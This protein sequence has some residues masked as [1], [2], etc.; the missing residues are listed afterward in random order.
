MFYDISQFFCC[1]TECISK[2]EALNEKKIY[3]TTTVEIPFLSWGPFFANSHWS[4]YDS[5]V[6]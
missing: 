6:Y 1:R 5:G 4:G 2:N 3:W